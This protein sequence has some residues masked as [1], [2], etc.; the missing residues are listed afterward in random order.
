MTAHYDDILLPS[1][2]RFYNGTDGPID[3][4]LHVRPMTGREEEILATQRYVKR[5]EALDRI[6]KACV[7][8][9]YDTAR[10]LTVDRNFL[11]IYLRVY[12][13]LHNMMWNYVAQNAMLDFPRHSI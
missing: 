3:G 7:R 10:F 4:K 12:L 6:F 9:P 5:G 8:E 1:N 11:L 2:G 13:I